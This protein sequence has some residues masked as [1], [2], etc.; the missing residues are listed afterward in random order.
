MAG[1]KIVYVS[2]LLFLLLSFSVCN[3]CIPVEKNDS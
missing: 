3:N 2:R 1:G